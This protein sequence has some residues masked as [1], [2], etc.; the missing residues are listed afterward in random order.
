MELNEDAYLYFYQGYI[1]AYF[2]F[3]GRALGSCFETEY[4]QFAT[5]IDFH[6]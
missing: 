2:Y 5:S 1:H 3:G 4:N 6:L